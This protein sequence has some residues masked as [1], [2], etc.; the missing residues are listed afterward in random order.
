M[1]I[2]EIT[3]TYAPHDAHVGSVSA[4]PRH[5]HAVISA[6]LKTMLTALREAREKRVFRRLLIFHESEKS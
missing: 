4:D 6:Q 1:G 5:S 3:R 2:L